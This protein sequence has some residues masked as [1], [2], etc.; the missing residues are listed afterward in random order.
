MTRP[1]TS[2]NGRGDC[3]T[4]A[5]RRWRSSG[6]AVALSPAHLQRR[7][8]SARFGLSPA[9]YLAQ[10]KLGKNSKSALR[11]GGDVNAALYDAILAVRPRACTG[12]RRAPGMTPAR[13]RAGGEGEELRWSTVDTAL[14]TALVAASARHLHGRARRRRTRAGG[15]AARRSS[16]NAA[17]QRVD[18]P[19]RLPRAAR[20]Y[21]RRCAGRKEGEGRGRPA[22]H[23]VPEKVWDALDAD[24]ARADDAAMPKSHREFGA[25]SA[26]RAVAGACARNR[27]AVLVPAIAWCAATAASAAT[28]G[29][30][31]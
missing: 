7:F 5:N 22:R 6:R 24:P 15:E 13:Y 20:A 28:A 23:R 18:A 29:A 17:L 2:S 19:R 30:C 26:A 14:G 9:E 4:A 1:T 8:P 21:G 16:P 3:S 25:P 12:R 31:R 11:E 10:R 27:I